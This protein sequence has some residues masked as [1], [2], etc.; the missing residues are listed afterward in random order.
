MPLYRIEKH[1]KQR[2]RQ[3]M[4]AVV[5]AGGQILKRGQELGQV[6]GVLERKL[7]KALAE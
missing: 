6:L 5:A 4:Y 1:P 3:G 2:S 7:I